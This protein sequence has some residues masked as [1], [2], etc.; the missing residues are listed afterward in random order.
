M[1]AKNTTNE[2]KTL[3]LCVLHFSMP[4]RRQTLICVMV[5][6]VLEHK[7]LKTHQVLKDNIFNYEIVLKVNPKLTLSVVF[8]FQSQKPFY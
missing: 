2:G 8:R 7:I 4:S 3:T 6:Y 1:Q 5:M